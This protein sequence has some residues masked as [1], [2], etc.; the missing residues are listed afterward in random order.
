MTIPESTEQTAIRVLDA[1]AAGTAIPYAT[2]MLDKQ[3]PEIQWAILGLPDRNEIAVVAQIGDL[4]LGKARA[5]TLLFPAMHDRIFGIDMSD[6]VL[7]ARLADELWAAYSERLI[8]AVL[9]RRG[10]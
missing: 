5:S 1:L 4:R 9:R 3:Y 6:Q 8:T 10:H 7:A 2:A